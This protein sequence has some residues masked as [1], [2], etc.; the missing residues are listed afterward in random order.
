MRKAIWAALAALFICG[1][2]AAQGTR[3]SGPVI[4]TT[5]AI[6]GATVR[7]C[8]ETATGT[9]CAPLASIYSDKAL[10]V[11][12]A[13]SIITADSAGNY[14]FY[15]AGGCY[16]I[17]TSASGY[18]TVTDIVCNGTAAGNIS[19]TSVSSPQTGNTAPVQIGGVYYPGTASGTA[20]APTAAPTGSTVASG[21][22][23]ADGTYYFK[24]TYKNRNGETTASPAQT[25]VISGGGGAARR[26]VAP[27]DTRWITGCYG[28]RVYAS[29]DNVNFYL[30]TPAPVVADFMTDT[31]THYVTMG[32]AGAR[33]DSLT[34]SGTTP[35]ATNTATIDPLQVALNATRATGTGPFGYGSA[36]GTL[37]VP[38]G[39]D[40]QTTWTLSTPLIM[41]A[42]E[43]ILGSGGPATQGN[44]QSRIYTSWA[45]AKL[46]NV[47]IF[48]GDVT[49]EQVGVLA[50]TGNAVMLL[51]GV[52]NQF[53]EGT[54]FLSSYFKTNDTTHTYSALVIVGVI[55]N[56]HVTNVGMRGDKAIV[57]YRNASGGV[58]YFTTGRWDAGGPSFI[59]SVPGWTNPD[60]GTHNAGFP[61]GVGGIKIKN[62][63]TELATGIAWDCVG[64]D[65][66]IE[67]SEIADLSTAAATDSLMKFGSDAT[68][69]GAGRALTL[70]NSAMPAKGN[71]RVGLNWVGLSGDI[72]LLGRSDVGSGGSTGPWIALDLN[73]IAGMIITN[74]AT[75]PGTN[76]DPASTGSSASDAKVIN[77]PANT[78]L[79]VGN[80]GYSSV[81]GTKYQIFGGGM[82]FM[83][84]VGSA[85]EHDKAWRIYNP[86]SGGLA[87][88]FVLEGG[89]FYSNATLLSI[90][91]STK[92]AT[93]YGAVSPSAPAIA[94]G[95]ATNYWAYN[96]TIG[97]TTARSGV[98]TTLTANT[99]LSIAGGTA[100]TTTNQTGT[101]SL[102]LATSPTLVTPVLGV[103]T[104]TSFQGIIGNVTPA[105]IT[106]TTITANTSTTSPLYNTTT[107]CSS[108]AS[109]AV[110]AAAPSG[111]VVIA[112]A[113]T[114][115]T[116]NTTAVTA[117]SQIFI[118]EDSSL[119]TKLSVTCNTTTGRTYTVTARTAATSFVITASAA[120]ATNPACLSY[121]VEN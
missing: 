98:F 64:L 70:I 69:G 99:S 111:S 107:N 28:Y 80:S 34:F 58:Q 101:G 74:F 39:T 96:G 18:T 31:W 62:I 65:V 63:R 66:T 92:A 14:G 94:H 112:A 25:V 19:V 41:R 87:R 37:Y 78:N 75:N 9:P 114:T 93:F 23:I 84:R 56:L 83:S 33:L 51:G 68:Y 35:P 13:D 29:I 102:V 53:G 1:S 43:H 49:I 10:T 20:S 21:G 8:T 6:P 118:Q 5:A 2:V 30:Q 57:E 7:V 36:I 109:P 55:Y 38:A 79:N 52:G 104:G 71:A 12:D 82:G 120:P 113:A 16:K 95:D 108:S 48:G 54:S 76:F 50:A 40:S 15:A 32:D 46:A 60:D 61:F 27:G 97:A 77:M 100:L 106:G 85:W 88:Q 24:I 81:A 73:N 67:D 17:Q 4:K 11:L 86:G 115:V 26:Y 116:V 119:G 91:Q 3:F 103:A 59:K 89:S 44:I 90:N 117:N 110:C 105:A 22:S 121:K 47:M 72:T 42:H 45:D